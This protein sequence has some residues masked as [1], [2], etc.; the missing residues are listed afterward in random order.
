MSSDQDQIVRRKA[1]KIQLSLSGNADHVDKFCDDFLGG[2]V[3]NEDEH[4]EVDSNYDENNYPDID[5]NFRMF[6][7]PIINLKALT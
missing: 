7:K 5:T 3:N 4:Q 6:R 1:I 2:T